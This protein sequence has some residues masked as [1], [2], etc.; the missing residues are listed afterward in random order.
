MERMH[1]IFLS[2]GLLAA[3]ALPGLV[4]AEATNVIR[5]NDESR[6]MVA[7]QG[8]ETG[9][10]LLNFLIDRSQ[11]DSLSDRDRLVASLLETILIN[12]WY[13]LGR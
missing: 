9:R 11:N 8:G 6:K 3:L 12:R 10:S 5:V 2:I 1:K 4:T 13:E 7:I